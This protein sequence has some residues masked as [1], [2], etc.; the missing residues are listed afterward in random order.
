MRWGVSGSQRMKTI[1]P[2]PSRSSKRSREERGIEAVWHGEWVAG[3]AAQCAATP[4]ARG[5]LLTMI[6]CRDEPDA[7]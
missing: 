1:R 6:W 3:P 5:W 2:Y 4:I 7:G